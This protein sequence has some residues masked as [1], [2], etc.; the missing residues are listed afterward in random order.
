MNGFKEYIEQPRSE[1][2]RY[3]IYETPLAL[4]WDEW[5]E[6]HEYVKKEFPIQSRVREFGYKTKRFYEKFISFFTDTYRNIFHPAHPILRKSIP[7]QWCDLTELIVD[8][9]FATIK[10]FHE[11]MKNNIVDWDANEHHSQFKA[12]IDDAVDYI[13]NRRPALCDDMEKC[14]DGMELKFSSNRTEQER[15]AFKKYNEIENSI[16]EMD[17]KLLKEMIEKRGFFWT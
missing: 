2:V 3:G 1:W 4:E 6:W 15:L 7:R 8:I 12:W 10:Q 11:E 13:D 5:D 17:T 16:N 14:F 9:G